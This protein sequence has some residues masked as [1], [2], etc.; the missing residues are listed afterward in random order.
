MKDLRGEMKAEYYEKNKHNRTELVK[1]KHLRVPPDQWLKLISYW[2]HDK[3]K[4]RSTTNRNNKKNQT[5][6]HSAGRKSF[7]CIRAERVLW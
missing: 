5:M 3:T 6:P 4:R 2:D 1:N 7:A